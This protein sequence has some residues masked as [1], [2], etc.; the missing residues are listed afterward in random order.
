MDL[1]DLFA[2][3]ELL[4]AALTAL[5]LLLVLVVAVVSA[6]FGWRI[7]RAQLRIAGG[8]SRDIIPYVDQPTD[9]AIVLLA[10]YAPTV[11]PLIVQ[12]APGVL[13]ALAEAFERV[14]QEPPPAEVNVGGEV[15]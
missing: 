4:Q 9:A 5:A 1:N 15:K 14:G 7:T 10:R 8:V 3:P 6:A 13:R 2:N 12:Y 11:A